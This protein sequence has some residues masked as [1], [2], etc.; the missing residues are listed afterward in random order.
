MQVM[1]ILLAQ[2][3]L[4]FG[5]TPNMTGT[6]PLYYARVIEIPTPRYTTYD[7]KFMGITAPEPAL[8]RARSVPLSGTNK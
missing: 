8:I 2:Y 6:K 4:R 5:K 3:P 1:R 7:A